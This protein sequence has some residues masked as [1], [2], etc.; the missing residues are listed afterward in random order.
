MKT[1]REILLQRHESAQPKLDAVRREALASITHDRPTV[2]P[3]SSVLKLWEELVLPCRG[4]W[5]GLAA[6]WLGLLVFHLSGSSPARPSMLAKSRPVNS[7]MFLALREQQQILNEL[8]GPASTSPA[9]A[10]PPRNPSTPHSERRT[11]GQAA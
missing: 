1:P 6:V 11:C 2:T 9:A 8:L 7:Q 3:A 4:I 10:A 5:A